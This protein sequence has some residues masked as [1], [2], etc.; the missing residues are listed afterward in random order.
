MFFVLTISGKK[1]KPIGRAQGVVFKIISC[2][3]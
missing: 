2:Q 3:S 1:Q